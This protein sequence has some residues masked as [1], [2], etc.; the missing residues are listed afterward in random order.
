[1]QLITETIQCPTVHVC[2]RMQS[3]FFVTRDHQYYG[4]IKSALM[5]ILKPASAARLEL[6]TVVLFFCS[7]VENCAS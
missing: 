7:P 2:C 6:F 3:E 4:T 5:L 1:M